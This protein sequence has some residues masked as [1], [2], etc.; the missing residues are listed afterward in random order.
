MLMNLVKV[1]SDGEAECVEQVGVIS[2][3]NV[4]PL[5]KFWFLNC[6]NN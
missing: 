1:G 5:N 6:M 2:L 3:I 4:H